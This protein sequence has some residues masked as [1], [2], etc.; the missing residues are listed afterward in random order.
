MAPKENVSMLLIEARSVDSARTS[1][2]RK[3]EI[4]KMAIM[5]LSEEEMAEFTQ[6]RQA[7]L[8]KMTR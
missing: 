2:R 4:L 6:R 7:Y 3:Q 5:S 1:L 8:R